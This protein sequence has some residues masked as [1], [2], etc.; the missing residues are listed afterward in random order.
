MV[1]LQSDVRRDGGKAAATVDY[2]RT[3][4]CQN[5]H[6]SNAPPL[7]KSDSH[8]SSPYSIKPKPFLINPNRYTATHVYNG[9][10]AAAMTLMMVAA[11]LK[12]I[13]ICH[14]GALEKK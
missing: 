6:R 5:K 2:F 12:M 9:N 8:S 14:W 3:G 10:A 13:F 7:P 11:F 1:V 4:S